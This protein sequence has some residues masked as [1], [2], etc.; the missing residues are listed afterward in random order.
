MTDIALERP[1]EGD[2]D[3]LMKDAPMPDGRPAIHAKHISLVITAGTEDR[4]QS[5][6]DLLEA[7]RSAV[8]EVPGVK[9]IVTVGQYY[10]LDGK[11]CLPDDYDPAT[12]GFKP[13]ATPPPWAG[14]PAPVHTKPKLDN[15]GKSPVERAEPKKKDKDADAVKA[16]MDKVIAAVAE[17][18]ED[19]ND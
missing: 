14:G 16:G 12:Q 6:E 4:D 3:Y 11:V 9:R 18:Q 15:V 13:G 17:A 1:V 2:E 19:S 7:V 10:I 5:I 8:A